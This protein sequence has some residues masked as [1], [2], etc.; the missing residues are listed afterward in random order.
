MPKTTS[1]T[2]L[3]KL[4]SFDWKAWNKSL[5]KGL[6]QP[7]RD[8]VLTTAQGAAKKVGAI[9]ALNDPLLSRFMTSYVLERAVQINETTKEA[10]AD[11]IRGVFA[12]GETDDSLA[13]LIRDKMREQFDGYEQWRANRIARSETAIGYNQANVL[14]FAQADVREVEVVDGTGDEVCESANG[15][16]WA[17]RE[18]LTKPIAHPNCTRSFLPV[19]PDADAGALPCERLELDDDLAFICAISSEL[20]IALED[21]CVDRILDAIEGED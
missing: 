20:I 9:F 5:E 8:L 1:T 10:V 4:E 14:G 19:I 16:M 21:P 15:Q 7:Y 18:A 11:L 12:S 17:L 3:K 13:N 2:L 6:F